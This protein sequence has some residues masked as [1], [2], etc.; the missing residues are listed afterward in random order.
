M[1][2]QMGDRIHDLRSYLGLS[3]SDLG[4]A[5]GYTGTHILRIEQEVVHPNE[6]VIQKIC[7]A[8]QVD[9]SYFTG[10]MVSVKCS[11]GLK[12]TRENE[13]IPPYRT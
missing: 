4:R 7:D 1:S 12:V 13:R 5:I 8:F 2:T 11:G 10:E 9:P 3:L 6:C